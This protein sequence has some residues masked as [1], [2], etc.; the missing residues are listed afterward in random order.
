MTKHKLKRQRAAPK[1]ETR[2]RNHMTLNT[3]IEAMGVGTGGHM[4][5]RGDV[6]PLSASESAPECMCP[7]FLYASYVPY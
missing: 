1:L 7:H 2:Q 6:P 4:G 5:H 3:S